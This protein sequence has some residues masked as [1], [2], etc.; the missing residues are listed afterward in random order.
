MTDA[1]RVEKA[2]CYVTRPR[3]GGGHELLAFTEPSIAPDLGPQV[4]G[5]TV[6]A[7]EPPDLAAV[8]ELLEETG[9]ARDAPDAHLG[10]YEYLHGGEVQ[11]RHVYHVA[12]DDLE[13]P[14]RWNHWERHASSG[15][16][17]VE[18]ELRWYPLDE[19]LVRTLIIGQGELIPALR[20]RL[21]AT[22]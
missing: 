9:I 3:V 2:H 20:Q 11:R 12:A 15:I 8:R 21:G 6:E 5:G 4:P 17:P 7:G 14:E 18:L 19:A 16:G 13:L 1:P 10:T 22:R